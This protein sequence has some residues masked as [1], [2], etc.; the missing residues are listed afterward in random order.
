M[1]DRETLGWI[2]VAL[3]IIAWLIGRKIE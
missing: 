3:I 1:I 2:V